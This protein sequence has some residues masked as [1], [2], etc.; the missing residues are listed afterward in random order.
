[1]SSAPM[2]ARARN[3]ASGASGTAWPERCCCHHASTFAS[4]A[5]TC[6]SASAALPCMMSMRRASSSELMM[7]MARLARLLFG[8]GAVEMTLA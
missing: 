8:L 5:S 7:L 3:S 6:G 4:R 1:M 2:S